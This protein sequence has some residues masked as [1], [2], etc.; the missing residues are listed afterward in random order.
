MGGGVTKVKADGETVPVCL[1]VCAR[2]CRLCAYERVPY[3]HQDHLPCNVILLHER[4][5]PHNSR[6]YI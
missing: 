1:C 4:Q 2:V 3:P 6:V 5:K